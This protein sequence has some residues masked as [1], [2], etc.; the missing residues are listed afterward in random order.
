MTST[1]WQRASLVGTVAAVL[2]LLA[3][4]TLR[5]NRPASISV[6]LARGLTPEAPAF[7]LPRLDGEG[8][9]D[10]AVLRGKVVV[11]NFWASWCVPCRDEA[12]ALE[13]TWQQYKDRGV[14]ILGVNVQDL[15]PEAQRFIKETK[16]TFPTVRDRDNSVYKAYGLTGVPETFF[17][18]RQG[19]IVRKF[20]GVVTDLRRWSE[21]VEDAL[22]R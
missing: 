18:D 20:P 2:G 16:T 13:A 1:T 7:V 14:I 15:I 11:I 17:V 3:F 9:I 22:A 21:S 12:P 5:T 6:A 8:I 4:V 10:L 19:R